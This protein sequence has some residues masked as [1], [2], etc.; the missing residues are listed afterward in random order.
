MTREVYER[1]S[2]L[3]QDAHDLLCDPAIQ[4]DDFIE[5]TLYFCVIRLNGMMN[6]LGVFG[7]SK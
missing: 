5:H 3:S 7:T 4:Q 2:K 1:L 6:K